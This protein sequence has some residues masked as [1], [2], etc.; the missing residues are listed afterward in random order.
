MINLVQSLILTL[1]SG[2][3]KRCCRW[4]DVRPRAGSTVD[5]F[6]P[7]NSIGASTPSTRD[8]VRWPEEPPTRRK[9]CRSTRIKTI[10]RDSG[11][12][13]SARNLISKGF[14][15]VLDMYRVE[16][17][18]QSV[19]IKREAI[20][21]TLRAMPRLNAKSLSVWKVEVRRVFEA[22]TSRDRQCR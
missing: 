11:E 2:F 22:R 6:M 5:A 14:N 3:R 18:V 21:N 16:A 13:S 7:E 19:Q 8:L 12:N 10:Q 17:V 1:G 15:S 20:M 9:E 4:A